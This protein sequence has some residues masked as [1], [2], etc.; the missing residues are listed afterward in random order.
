M[1]HLF[2][3]GAG[4][5]GLGTAVGFARLGHAITV[6]DVDAERISLLRAGEPPAFEPGM[7]DAIGSLLDRGVLRFTTDLAPPSDAVVTFVCVSTPTGPDGPLFTGH[8]EDAVLGL[9]S[10]V[11]QDH[12]IVVRST[13]PLDGPARLR[14]AIGPRLHRVPV[15]TNPEFMREGQALE[16]FARPNRVVVGWLEARDAPS[17]TVLEQLYAPLEA[18]CIVADAGSVALI[19][20][21]SNVFLG[22]KIAYANE[23]ARISEVIGADVGTV[24]AGVGL[25]SRIGTTFMQPGPGFGGSCLPEQALAISLETAGLA[26]DAPL[27]SSIHR[28]NLSHQQSIVERFGR[29]L[30]RDGGL[31]GA[32]VALLGLSFK[33]NTDDVRESPG[34]A[35][36]ALMRAAGAEVVGHDPR[37]ARKATAVDP[38][39]VTA[40]TVAEA[41]AGSDA[42]LVATEWPEYSEI[43]WVALGPLMRGRVVYDTRGVVRTDAARAAGL[44]VERLGAPASALERVVTGGEGSSGG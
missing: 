14:H 24:I 23:V 44:R 7:A 32:R 40:P 19:K 36:A 15:L 41:I 2:V 33:A 38:D 1:A 21:L 34:L 43:D 18:P 22:M 5:V 4:H 10:V 26:I 30:D 3:L 28:S 8:V 13:L 27:L 17:A 20:L 16:D 9:I 37:A 6:A 25:D 39:L 11:S 12:V 31:A 29:L 35:L 42:V